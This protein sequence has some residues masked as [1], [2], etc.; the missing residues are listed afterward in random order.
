MLFKLDSE[1]GWL[2]IKLLAWLRL[3]GFVFYPGVPNTTAA[4]Q[5]TDRNYGPFKTA[6]RIILDKCFQEMM[7]EKKENGTQSVA[8][9]SSCIWWGGPGDWSIIAEECLPRRLLEGP[10]PKRRG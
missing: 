6:F 8:C 1:P 10:V 3:L 9:W 2:G 5:S 4:S 7:F